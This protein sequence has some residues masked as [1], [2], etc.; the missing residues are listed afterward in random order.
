M[1]DTIKENKVNLLFDVT[2]ALTGIS[3]K[4]IVG[5]KRHKEYILP[6]HIVGY[7]L[8]KELEITMI[9]SGKLV[10]R[11]HS[12]IHHYCKT[13]ED[14][15]KFYKEF[16]QLY[17]IISES[18]WS[19]IMEADVKDMSL[20]LKQLQNLIDILTEKKKKLLTITN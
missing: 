7:M 13:H 2:E 20:E 15:M 16:R 18:F 8:H 12:T 5:K 11:D 4:S 1:K 3:R 14:N 19:Q 6:R 17:K 9:E 10:G